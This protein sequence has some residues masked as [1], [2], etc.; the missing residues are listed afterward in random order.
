MMK[1]AQQNGLV[2]GFV[3]NLVDGGLV[4]VQYADGT[5]FLFEDNLE[6]SRNLK[7]ILCIFVQVAGLKINFHNSEVFCLGDDVLREEEYYEIFTCKV[8]KPRMKYLGMPI[9]AKR[10]SSAQ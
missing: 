7:F 4:L 9:D 3:P 5:I 6:N 8:E 10:L 1:N 2:H